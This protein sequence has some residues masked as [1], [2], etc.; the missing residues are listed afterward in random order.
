MKISD[1]NTGLKWNNQYGKTSGSSASAPDHTPA[2]KKASG[3]EDFLEISDEAVKRH[4]EAKVLSFENGR[5]K[6]EALNAKILIEDSI[7]RD[8]TTV[9]RIKDMIEND[10]YDFNDVKILGE[11]AERVLGFIG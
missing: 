7:S 10:K 5:R 11:T 4:K 1:F 8:I 3:G 6:R 2:F 9:G